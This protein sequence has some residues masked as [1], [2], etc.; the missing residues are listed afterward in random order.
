MAVY[1]V[2]D[3]CEAV[4][5]LSNFDVHRHFHKQAGTTDLGPHGFSEIG[6]AQAIH[7]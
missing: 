4:V 6:D 7:R 1:G 2:C 5:R 3:R